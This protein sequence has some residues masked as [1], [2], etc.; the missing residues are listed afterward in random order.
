MSEAFGQLSQA[1]GEIFETV[2]CRG[3]IL[4]SMIHVGPFQHR[5]FYDFITLISWR[6]TRQPLNVSSYPNH[7]VI[8]CYSCNAIFLLWHSN[9]IFHQHD[10]HSLPGQTKWYWSAKLCTFSSSEW[11][12]CRFFMHRKELLMARSH[13]VNWHLGESG[14]VVNIGKTLKIIWHHS[15]FPNFP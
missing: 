10:S 6:W 14:R 5:I 7:S 15:G 3:R 1:Q 13:W 9:G 12:C 11:G 8:L 4:D 2:L